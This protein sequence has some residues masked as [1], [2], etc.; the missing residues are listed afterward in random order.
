MQTKHRDECKHSQ[1][2]LPE[3]MRCLKGHRPRFYT[4]KTIT[5]AQRGEFGWK[6]KCE[7]FE[8]EKQ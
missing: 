8:Q 6:R 1:S 7:D 3:E 4:P 5:Q 2:Y